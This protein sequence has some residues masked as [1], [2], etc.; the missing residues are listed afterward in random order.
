[1]PK[2]STIILCYIETWKNFLVDDIFIPVK[3]FHAAQELLVKYSF[4]ENTKNYH[5]TNFAAAHFIIFLVRN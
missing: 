3:L 5:A 2:F 1:M 4:C